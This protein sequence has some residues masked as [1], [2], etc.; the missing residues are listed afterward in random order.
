MLSSVEVLRF[1][2]LKLCVD[3]R[4]KGKLKLKIGRLE[5]WKIVAHCSLLIVHCSSPQRVPDNF[6]G[7]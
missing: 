1:E 2:V 4:E 3:E 5:D 7:M 6:Y